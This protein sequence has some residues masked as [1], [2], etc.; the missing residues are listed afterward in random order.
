MHVLLKTDGRPLV[1]DIVLWH[2]AVSTPHKMKVYAEDGAKYT[3]STLVNKTRN[4]NTV[5]IKNRGHLEFPL[6]ACVGPDKEAGDFCLAATKDGKSE[7]IQG[8]FLCS[9]PFDH[10]VDSVAVLIKTNNRPL[11]ARIELLQRPK[12]NKQALELYTEDGLDRPFIAVVHTPGSGN[13]V[14][15]VNTTC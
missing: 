8:G 1:A 12:S 6:H 11:N 10:D 4:P 9:Y 5:C 15:V 13:V 3:F 7:V 2:G 14:Q